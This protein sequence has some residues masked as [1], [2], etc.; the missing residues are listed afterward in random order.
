MKVISFRLF[1]NTE[2]YYTEGYAIPTVILVDHNTITM[3]NYM[4]KLA[5][6][7]SQSSKPA[8]AVPFFPI[9]FCCNDTSEV[10]IEYD[11][12]V[13]NNEVLSFTNQTNRRNSLDSVMGRLED[14]TTTETLYPSEYKDL[15]VA[16]GGA[17]S[18]ESEI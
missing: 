15:E 12:V 16:G 6:A 1:E 8:A 17:L 2:Y 3:Q 18:S 9:L 11:D 10:E 13:R 14:Y 7:F 5:E 4:L